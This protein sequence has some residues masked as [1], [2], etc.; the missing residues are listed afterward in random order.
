MKTAAATILMMFVLGTA[1]ADSGKN[2]LPS[3]A[4]P[5]WKTPDW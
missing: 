5:C 3:T 1:G 2:S 4:M